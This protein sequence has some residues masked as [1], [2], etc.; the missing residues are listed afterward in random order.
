MWEIQRHRQFQ[1]Q[2]EAQMAIED[3]IH[4]FYNRQRLHQA[5]D[6]RSPEGFDR[7]ESGT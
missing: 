7:Q 3:Y 1:N 5:P 4:R 6:Y 2:V